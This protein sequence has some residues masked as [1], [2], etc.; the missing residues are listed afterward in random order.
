MNDTTIQGF[1]CLETKFKED[2]S[3]GHMLFFK[4][5]S[6][7]NSHESKPLGQTLFVV[8]VPPYCTQHSL[9]RMF[10]EAG[11]VKK[12]F[13]QE[14][15]S[16]G[17]KEKHDKSF[18][19]TN[20]VKGFKVGYVIFKQPG[21]LKKAMTMTWSTKFNCTEEQPV[22]TGIDKWVN[23]YETKFIES[24]LL[25]KTV[26]EFMRLYDK[27]KDKEEKKLK[28]KEGVAD[29]DGWITVTKNSRHA[30]VAR[31]ENME[32]K[33]MTNEKKKQT[34]KKLVNFY[35]FQLRESKME[36]LTQM[37]QKFEEDKRRIAAMKASRRFKPY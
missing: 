20:V 21:S 33:V 26:D 24:K 11:S 35:G 30:G 12:V 3:A 37:R 10:S 15:P 2:C 25:Q 4:E 17:E 22:K 27:S 31:T 36:H 28:A 32:Q 23:N 5:H 14:K 34:E 6:V 18:F 19:K 16:S 13:F 8:N 1:R 9:L 29:E 7:R